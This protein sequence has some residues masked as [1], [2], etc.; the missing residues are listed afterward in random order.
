MQIGRADLIKRAVQLHIRTLL[1]GSLTLIM[2]CFDCD[3]EILKPTTGSAGDHFQWSECP[4]PTCGE[5]WGPPI[6][7]MIFDKRL[8]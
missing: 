2:M 3:C 5:L 8:C 7:C 1:K 4:E 6:K